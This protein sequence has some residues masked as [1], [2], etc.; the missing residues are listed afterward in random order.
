MSVNM[1]VNDTIVETGL[2]INNQQSLSENGV[3]STTN[4]ITTNPNYNVQITENLEER[5]TNKYDDD[6][7]TLSNTEL[8][9][10]QIRDYAVQIKCENFHGKGNIDDYSAL[11]QAASQ[12]ANDTK[13]MNLDIDIDGFNDFANAAD[14]LSNLFTNFTKRLQNINIINDNS[15]L[16]AVLNALKKIVNL[17]N[18]FGKF[19]ETIMVTSEIKIPK[20]T[21]DTKNI[22]VDVIAEVNCAMNYINNFVEPTNN[23]PLANLSNDEKNV[24]NKAVTTIDNWK[25]LC[26][27]GVS[28][29]LNNDTDINY[30]KQTNTELKTKTQSLQNA[31]SKL[32]QK[33]TLLNCL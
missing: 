6:P 33:L 32:R 22:L 7:N 3:V 17:S 16:I 15:F 28:I 27:N 31:T 19:K 12:I 13:Q 30:L 18:V 24:I 25:V 23:L 21:H 14:E 1:L 8:I 29:A 5:V 11:F 26:E 20:T 4:F 2:Q 9:V 10:E